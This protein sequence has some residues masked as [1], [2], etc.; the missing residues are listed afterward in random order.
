MIVPQ[1]KRLLICKLYVPDAMRQLSV[2]LIVNLI[3]RLYAFL[4]GIRLFCFGN[5][6]IEIIQTP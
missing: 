1:I 5:R 2:L 6:H 4:N 3:K